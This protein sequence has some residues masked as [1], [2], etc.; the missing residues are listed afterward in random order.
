MKYSMSQEHQELAG[1][2]K[3]VGRRERFFYQGTDDFA[4]PAL[5]AHNYAGD[6]VDLVI[7]VHYYRRPT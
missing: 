6:S 5:R 7:Q 3:K 2:S 1:A 4:I